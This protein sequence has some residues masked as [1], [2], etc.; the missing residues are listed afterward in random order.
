[1]NGAHDGCGPGT[2]APRTGRIAGVAVRA[3]GDNAARGSPAG[4]E[5]CG[6]RP[7]SHARQDIEREVTA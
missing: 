6:M 7:A 1:M 4:E 3:G 5:G 2:P